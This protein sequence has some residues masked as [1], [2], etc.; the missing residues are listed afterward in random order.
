MLAALS[1]R[2]LQVWVEGQRNLARALGL[3]IEDW[4]RALEAA[5]K[6]KTGLTAAVIGASM[7]RGLGMTVLDALDPDQLLA[8]AKELID[9]EPPRV[10][11]PVLAEAIRRATEL[12]SGGGAKRLKAK[13]RDISTPQRGRGSLGKSASTATPDAPGREEE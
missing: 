6:R 11:N 1:D 10:E 7:A 9:P 4:I 3:S 12:G 2:E 5:S 13:M 8:R